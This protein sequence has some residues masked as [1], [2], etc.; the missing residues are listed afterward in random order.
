MVLI[1]WRFWQ[2]RAY[3][4]FASRI[5]VKYLHHCI[6][7]CLFETIHQMLPGQNLRLI[8]FLPVPLSEHSR[9]VV[10]LVVLP[11]LDAWHCILVFVLIVLLVIPPLV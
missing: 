3:H 6:H 11:V 7:L 8:A 5:A 9:H 4:Y 10:I 2:F 1:V